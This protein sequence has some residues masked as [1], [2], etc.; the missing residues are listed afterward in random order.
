VLNNRARPEHIKTLEALAADPAL[1]ERELF[2]LTEVAA[3]FAEEGAL[4]VV[5]RLAKHPAA[6]VRAQLA[7]HLYLN[8]DKKLK[9]RKTL[10]LELS[11]DAAPEVRAAALRAFGDFYTSD[12]SMVQRVADALAKDAAPEVKAAAL[13]TISWAA[14]YASV[15]V[16]YAA[17]LPH[18]TSPF[19]EVRQTLADQVSSLPDDPRL[20]GIVKALLADAE[21]AVRRRMAWQSC[22]L[23][24]FQ[25]L[26][27]LFAAA[28]TADAAVEVRGDALQGLTRLMPLDQALALYAER[29]AKDQAEV[30]Y[31][32]VVNGLREVKQEPAARAMLEQV[33]SSRTYS[34]PAR[35]A[36]DI[37]S[38]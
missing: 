25:R 28:A 1:T 12:K 21:V 27:P 24:E 29:L 38:E 14:H 16:V 17:V 34:E 22:N 19:L 13:Q 6:P 33:A 31:W 32:G 3:K 4:P 2:A 18:V 15:D 10:L 5:Q 11:N 26:A 23:G 20:D 9:E 30:V 35:V 8:A 37:L 7:T 36:R